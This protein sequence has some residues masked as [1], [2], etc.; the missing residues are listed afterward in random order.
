MA[1]LMAS[2]SNNLGARG[3]GTWRMTTCKTLMGRLL[4]H[5]ALMIWMIVTTGC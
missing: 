2:M 5:M 1:R 3:L 4:T